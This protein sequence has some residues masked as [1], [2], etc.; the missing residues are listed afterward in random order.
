MGGRFEGKSV[1][2]T[3]AGSGFG[4][5]TALRFAKEGARHI[6]LGDVVRNRLQSVA[7]EIEQIG[8]RAH[9]LE[10]NVTDTH[11]SD[12]AIN[13]AVGIAERLDVVV[14]NVA[15]QHPEEPFLDMRDE[16]WLADVAGI[17]TASFVIG[18]RAA[19]HM[20]KS[21]GGVILYTIS[22]SAL[23]ASRGLVGY[24]AAKAGVVNLVKAM[25][26]ELA[27]YKIR[28]NGVSP[29]PADTMRSVV[30]LGEDA[31]RKLRESFP[32]VPLNRLATADDIAN[33][34]VYLASDEASY[35]TGQNLVVD[36]GL[37]AQLYDMPKF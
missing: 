14:S 37:T 5:A 25:A 31:M 22:I 33:A 30:A 29:G 35:V 8:S 12:A 11:A 16:T 10:W 32:I 7:V 36:G 2:I 18:Q 13:K 24:C 17:L 19:R 6:F 21:G 4:R 20:A 1:L 26:V 15:P 28:V 27:P 34:F 3:G 23:G 9:T